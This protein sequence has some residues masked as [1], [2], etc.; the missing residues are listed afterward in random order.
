[1]TDKTGTLTKNEMSLKKLYCNNYIYSL[2]TS[3]IHK[4]D[5]NEQTRM[6][7]RNILVNNS[8][9]ISITDSSFSY[10]GVSPEEMCTVSA[11][12]SLGR[13]YS[14]DEK[15]NEIEIDL[16]GEKEHYKVIHVYLISNLLGSSSKSSIVIVNELLSLSTLKRDTNIICLLRYRLFFLYWL[17]RVLMMSFSLAVW[18]FNSFLLLLHCRNTRARRAIVVRRSLL[19]KL[20]ILSVEWGNLPCHISWSLDWEPWLIVTVRWRRLKSTL[21]SRP[22]MR[23]KLCLWIVNKPKMKR[24]AFSFCSI[25]RY[26]QF[27]INMMSCGACGIEDALQDNVAQSI[28]V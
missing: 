24:I 28:Q 27:E 21:S 18:T 3:Y 1:M 22:S 16:F 4:E 11:I 14:H 12:S 25:R 6:L 19:W 26:N 9:K 8:L 23:L 2:D 5:V 7:I 10:S 15:S 20:L 13:L 17:Y